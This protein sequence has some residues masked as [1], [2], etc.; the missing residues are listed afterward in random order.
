MKRE[1]RSTHSTDARVLYEDHKDERAGRVA[2][3]SRPVHKGTNRGTGAQAGAHAA[4]WSSGA[5]TG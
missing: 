3:G 5:F 1:A 4:D 2:T